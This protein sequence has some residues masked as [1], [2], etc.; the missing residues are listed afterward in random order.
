MTYIPLLFI[1]KSTRVGIYAVHEATPYLQ[2]FSKLNFWEK[3]FLY[4]I[5]GFVWCLVEIFAILK[6][7]QEA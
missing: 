2:L 4:S 5:N 3:Y 6:S 1:P 7:L